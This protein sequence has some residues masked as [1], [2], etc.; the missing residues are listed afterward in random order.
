MATFKAI[1]PEAIKD[2]PFKL[3]GKDWMLITAGDRHAFNTMTASWG[4]MGVLWSKP[5]AF[6]FIRPTR[7]TF[8]FADK[9][10]CFTLSF[11]AG[12]YRKALTFCGTHSGRD[13]DKVAATG[14]APVFDRTGAIYFAQARLVLVCRKLYTTDI[15]PKRFLDPAIDK[16]YPKKDYHRAFVGEVV[17]VLRKGGRG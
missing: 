6:C 8:G 7:H 11:F 13:T 5:V 2:N 10:G 14:L 4:T 16:N 12:K 3:V 1:K 15:D 17:K 9:A